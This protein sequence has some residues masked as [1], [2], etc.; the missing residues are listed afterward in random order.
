MAEDLVD[1]KAHQIGTQCVELLLVLL[2]GYEL[3]RTDRRKIGRMAEKYNPSTL[4]VFGKLHR[5]MGGLNLD[6]REFLSK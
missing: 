3:C 5:A 4:A 6:G 1:R 2:E